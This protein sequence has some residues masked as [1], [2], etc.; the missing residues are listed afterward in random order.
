MGKNAWYKHRTGF[1]LIE[2]LV[3]IAIIAILAGLLLPALSQARDKAR[4]ATCMNNLKQIGLAILMYA[5]DNNDYL[6]ARM[7]GMVSTFWVKDNEPTYL[8]LVIKGGY[9]KPNNYKV[10]FCPSQSI[11]GNTIKS[12]VKSSFQDLW[13]N[14]T[15]CMITYAQRQ[16]AWVRGGGGDPYY[17]TLWPKLDRSVG[18]YKFHSN[19][20]YVACLHRPVEDNYKTI[21]H[22]YV[23]VNVWYLGGHAKFIKGFPSKEGLGASYDDRNDWGNGLTE[24]GV[25]DGSWWAYIDSVKK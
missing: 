4:Q 1:T 13:N 15:L 5:N 3:V 21:A 8:G 18:G 12:F 16:T 7:T 9:I 6:P 17:L 22:K 24:S 14:N 10:L 23:G 2:L 19:L 25:S 20:G 11:E